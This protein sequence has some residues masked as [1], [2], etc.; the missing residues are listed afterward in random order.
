MELRPIL[1][2]LR[3]HKT[4]S[5][6]I[7][8]EI[9]LSCAIICNAM[10]L[11]GGRLERMDRPTGLAE[12]EIVRIQITGIGQDDNAMALTQSDLAA[13]RAL[14]GVKSASVTNQV[15]FGGSSWN[16]GVNLT[17]DQ[18]HV[19]LSATTYLGDEQLPETLGLKL[20]AGRFFNAD[21]L[22]D[23]N[24]FNE[25]GANLAVPV[26]I[27]T[28]DM[29]DELWPGEDPLGKTYYSWGEGG[30]RVVGVVDKLAR[31]NTQGGPD[32]YYYSTILP[33]RIPFNVGGNYLLRVDP[34][35]RSE[36]LKAAVEALERNGPN[37][38]VLEQQTLEE[39]RSDYYRQDRAMAWMLVIVS[40]L[41][42]VVTALGIV[43]L[44]SFWVA[45][46]TKQIGVRRALGATRGQILRYFQV[47]NFVLATLGIVVGMMLAY[48]INQ[49]MMER[50][51]LSRL[52][53]LYLPVGAVVLWL[54]GQLSVLGPARRAAAVP[55]AVAT[56]SV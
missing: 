53:A 56:R 13:L 54:L 22:V 6:L 40:V 50:A 5:A 36:T 11:I 28:K 33:L 17:Q 39:M 35:R 14:P 4:A 55:P 10:F 41:L 2:T 29:A 31:P 19:N 51:E 43:G 32:S 27:V 46:R 48:G 24:A 45:Q 3:R 26:A 8:L 7:V 30:T 1:S 47:E 23:W 16:S 37:R 38:I 42:L 44:A 21:E 12:N 49:M 15:V 20:V 9:A 34:E 52:P 18:T 25:P